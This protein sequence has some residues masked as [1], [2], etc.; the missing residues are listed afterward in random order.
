MFE[1]NHATG[2]EMQ[3]DRHSSKTFVKAK[4]P[5]VLAAGVHSPQVLQ[6][7]GIGPKSLLDEHGIKTVV[8]LSGVGQNFQD[9]PTLYAVF[10]F[11]KPLSPSSDDLEDNQAFINKQLSFYWTQREGAYTIV[12]QGG[13]TVAFL[14]LP[15]I[16]SEYRTVVKFAKEDIPQS[17]S[18]NVS[19]ALTQGF[20]AQRSIIAEMYGSQSTSVQETG[21]NSG[22]TLPITLVKPLSRGSLSIKSNNIFDEPAVDFGT[23]SHP[24]DLEIMVAAL[25][26]NRDL[27]KTPAMQETAPVEIVP[28]VNVTA[29][30][31]MREA[32]RAN[33]QP[34]YSHP[35]CACPM[36]PEH[37]GGVVDSEL[38][39]HGVRGLSVVDASIMPM[40]PAMHLSATVYAVA[41]KVIPFAPSSWHILAVLIM[42]VGCR[43][44]QSE[45]CEET[46]R[47]F[48]E[49][50]QTV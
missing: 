8:D 18:H 42:A 11:K 50:G 48:V 49:S 46:I 45:A 25:R 22:S 27:M 1:G 36:M 30:A 43:Y 6:L 19:P 32:I 47:Q 21:W 35:C 33:A 28:G 3:A 13:N 41:E 24:A 10:D 14:P 26:I 17:S 2:V 37:S 38:L 29:D 16:T 5:V 34:T 9:H 20:R 40:I 15:N 7:S 12:H 44:N 39:V 23:F 4:K 31:Q